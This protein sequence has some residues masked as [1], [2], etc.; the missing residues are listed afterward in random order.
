MSLALLRL[1]GLC[2]MTYALTC[3]WNATHVPV[4]DKAGSLREV[5]LGGCQPFL[6]QAGP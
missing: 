5:P 6:P 4:S 3:T 1:S 2:H